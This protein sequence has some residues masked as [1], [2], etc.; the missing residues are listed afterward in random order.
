MPRTVTCHICGRDF[1]SASIGIHI[2]QCTKKWEAQELQKPPNQ[3]RP[4]PAAPDN[5]GATSREEYNQRAAQSWNDEALVACQHC[6]RTFLPDRL[7]VH[8]RSCKPPPGAPRP[9]GQSSPQGAAAAAVA[10]VAANEGAAAASGAG[11]SPAPPQRPRM[12]TC[13]ICGREFGST[14]I[15]IHL[16]QCTKKWEAQEQQKPAKERR[17]VP[18]APDCAVGSEDYNDAA[19]Q[20]WKEDALVPCPNCGRTFLPDRL[21]I[22]LRSCKRQAGAPGSMKWQA[23]AATPA[24]KESNGSS[25]SAPSTKRPSEVSKPKGVMCY[26]CGREFGSHSIDIHTPQCAKKWEAHEATKPLSERRP[27]PSA[28]ENASELTREEF[29]EAAQKAWNEQALVACDGCG[30]TFLP[31]RLEVHQ[32]SCK[33]SNAGGS[34][35]STSKPTSSSA[36]ATATAEA[37]MLRKPKTVVCHICGRDFGS[38]SI[39]IHLPQCAKKWEQQESKKPEGQRRP[40]PSLPEN[41]AGI[42]R[43]EYNTLAAKR[44]NTEALMPCPNCAR[45]FLPDRLEVHLRSCRPKDGNTSSSGPSPAASQEGAGTSPAG[46]PAAS[47]LQKPKSARPSTVVCHICGREF[48]SA[49]IDIHIP[50]CE[51]RWEA[52][53]QQKPASARRPLPTKPEVDVAGGRTKYNEAARSNFN[54]EA[55]VPCPNCGRTFLPDRL[56]VHLRSCHPKDDGPAVA[57]RLSQRPSVD[58][59]AAAAAD[60]Q[61]MPSPPSAPLAKPRSV[62]CHICGRDFGTKSIDIHLPQCAKKWEVQEMKKPEAERRPVPSAPQGASRK[63]LAEYN[64]AALQQWNDEALLP[65][66]HCARTFLPDRLEV[67]LRSC[68]P[69]AA[70]DA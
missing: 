31:D 1:G 37:E 9:K 62:T 27:V 19:R 56:E 24:A 53:E 11:S 43:D 57:K 52:Q 69:R 61:A 12:V 18:S 50:Q 15:D 17:S 41:E 45:T 22:H 20:C 3:R 30:R 23:P 51:K 35:A 7:E 63:S 32:R 60:N 68:K 70:S 46:M 36:T 40:V 2:P 21:E 13:H 14:S 4:V 26:I 5:N 47:P 42:S 29:N 59:A 66:P 65:C 10:A 64:E 16:P 44:F 28:P 6:G 58:A 38:A 8:L 49:S 39:D 33:G 34:M 25:S 48:G 55:L 67:H 54:T